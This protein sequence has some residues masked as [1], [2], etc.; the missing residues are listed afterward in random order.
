MLISEKQI[1]DMGV[2]TAPRPTV[3]KAGQM[4]EVSLLDTVVARK[5]EVKILQ[6]AQ[7]YA[8]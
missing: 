3:R 1:T 4:V 7:R 2:V 5:Q 6:V 8:S